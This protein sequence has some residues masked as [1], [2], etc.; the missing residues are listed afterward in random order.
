M[1]QERAK[2]KTIKAKTNIRIS[3][4]QENRC[5]GTDEES[6]VVQQSYQPARISE[7]LVGISWLKHLP[8]VDQV[9]RVSMQESD[10]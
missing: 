4:V 1:S 5:Y 3:D 8:T 6:G 7:E 9:P 2:T 10:V